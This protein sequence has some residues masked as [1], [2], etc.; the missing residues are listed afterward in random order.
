MHLFCCNGILF[1]WLEWESHVTSKG[2]LKKVN[3][4]FGFFFFVDDDQMEPWC[5]KNNDKGLIFGVREDCVVYE[6]WLKLSV[7]FICEGAYAGEEFWDREQ[8]GAWAEISAG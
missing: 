4:D 2:S 1:I 8:T 7:W 6:I 3:L 5:E